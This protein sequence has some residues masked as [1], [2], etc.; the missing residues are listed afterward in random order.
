MI[1]ETLTLRA[2]RGDDA[3]Y[4]ALV[5]LWNAVHPD[6]PETVEQNRFYDRARDPD[7][8]FMRVVAEEEGRVVGVGAYGQIEGM[9]HPGMFFLDA[10]VHPGAQGRGVG[11]ALYAHMLAALAPL[12][13]RI[14]CAQ[15]REGHARALRFLHARGFGEDKRDWES[16]LELR[17]FDPATFELA[18][19]AG[20]E[21][22]LRAEGIVLTTLA[23][24]ATDPEMPRKL[25]ELFSEVR[26]DI[27]R[28]EPPTLISFERFCAWTFA[29]PDYLPEAA[30]VALH[31]ER[32]IG[33]SQ[34]WKRGADTGLDTGLTA[35]RR[36]Y[37]GRGVA[38]AMKL[39]AIAIAKE[40]GASFI[41][42]DNDARNAPMLA[43]NA[44]LGFA[45]RPAWI[46]FVK[47]L[48]AERTP[49][50]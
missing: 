49:Q 38:L 39:R 36:G 23:E 20:L 27:P 2:F 33:M 26:V 34:L 35:V 12:Q 9:M 17:T 41:R 10:Q 18:P 4:Q 44:K 7:C 8:L 24:L 11:K 30:V 15:A 22:R 16:R 1:A 28:S 13:P 45:R 42:T 3:D 40:L 48:E 19:Y 31:G 21:A 50:P 25:Y 32:Y 47:R 37:R 43:I 5:E 29:S 14:L 46:S 6:S